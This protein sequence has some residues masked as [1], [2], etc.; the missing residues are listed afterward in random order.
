MTVQLPLSD[1][2]AACHPGLVSRGDAGGG[3]GH[4]DDD[5]DGLEVQSR[6][7]TWQRGYDTRVESLSATAAGFVAQ[8]LRGRRSREPSKTNKSSSLTSPALVGSR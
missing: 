5:S 4:L 3:D 8:I 7:G 1:S 6:A 2:A